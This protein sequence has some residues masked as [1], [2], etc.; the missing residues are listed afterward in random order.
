WRPTAWQRL[1]STA[2][3]AWPIRMKPATHR[4]YKVLSRV[5]AGAEFG[6]QAPCANVGLGV[7]PRST[8][9]IVT[10]SDNFN[11]IQD[12][13]QSISTTRPICLLSQAI[14]FSRRPCLSFA[15]TISTAFALGLL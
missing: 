11:R 5:N 10:P 12:S 4:Q 9:M 1:T 8:P 15:L 6:G 13:P 14:L 3:Q 7:K 2:S